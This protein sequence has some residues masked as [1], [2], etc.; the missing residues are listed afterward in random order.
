G[1][2]AP[3]AAGEARAPRD[4]AQRSLSAMDAF[5][6]KAL[7]LLTSEETQNAF[8]IAQEPDKTRDA[9]GRNIYGQSVL[10][11]RRLIEAGTR[12]VTISWAPDANA[13]WDTHGQ[14]FAKLKNPLL[15]Q[16]DAAIGSLLDDLVDRGMLERTL[17]AVLGDF[18]RTPKVNGGAG[19]DHW[20]YCY[21]I[22]LLGGGMKAGYVHGASDKTGAFPA[23]DPV[24]PAQIIATMYHVLGVAEETELRDSLARPHRL[25]PEGHLLTEIL[26]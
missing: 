20:N 9:Y 14:N 24:T 1:Q 8:R 6:H 25:V 23:R 7:E 3:A 2:R 4:E 13:T 21:T 22:M 10:L 5:Q 17:V 16:F 12:M 19:R 15:P 11:A 26:A 18:G